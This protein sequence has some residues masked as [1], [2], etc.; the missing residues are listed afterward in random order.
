M[1]PCGPSP[2]DRIRSPTCLSWR[3]FVRDFSN[4]R[5]G[6]LPRDGVPP[7]PEKPYFFPSHKRLFFFDPFKSTWRIFPELAESFLGEESSP[8]FLRNHF[9]FP[10]FHVVPFPP[11]SFPCDSFPPSF[12]SLEIEQQIFIL[13]SL[14]PAPT[15]RDSSS[16]ASFLPTSSGLP[17]IQ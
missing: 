16:P 11:R 2:G 5:F 17:S 9:P 14:F 4:G 12:F 1:S 6:D 13:F 8:P 3:T 10:F 15:K 7:F